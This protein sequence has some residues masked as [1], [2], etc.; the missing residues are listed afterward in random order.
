[1]NSGWKDNAILNLGSLTRADTWAY[2]DLSALNLRSLEVPSLN[3]KACSW[4]FC[5]IPQTQKRNAF[6]NQQEI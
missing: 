3:P 2:T 1:M 6:H 4:V 5:P